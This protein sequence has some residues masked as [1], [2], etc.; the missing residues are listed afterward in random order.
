MHILGIAIELDSKNLI[1]KLFPQGCILVPSDFVVVECNLH[2]SQ[3]WI[4]GGMCD[5]NTRKH[6]EDYM[7]IVY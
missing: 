2:I 3:R 1:K 7:Y 6:C 4:V 5:E